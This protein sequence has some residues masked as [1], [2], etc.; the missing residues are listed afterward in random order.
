MGLFVTR[1]KL[2]IGAIITVLLALAVLWAER[3]RLGQRAG[4]AWLR[5]RG[6]PAAGEIEAI[7]PRGIVVRDLALGD[8][9]HPDLAAERAQIALAWEGTHPRLLAAT[10]VRPVLRLAVGRDGR[11]HLGALDRLRPP[12]D[13]TPSR[14]PDLALHLTDARLLASTPYGPLAATVHSDGNPARRFAGTLALAPARLTVAGCALPLT[15]GRLTIGARD[16]VGRLA[17]TLGLGALACRGVTAAVTSV[18]LDLT[19][20]DP[21]TRAHG[22]IVAD[23]RRAGGRGGTAERATI[24]FDGDLAPERVAGRLA[25]DASGGRYGQWHAARATYQGRLAFVPT[26]RALAL[27]GPL[28]IDHASLAP[29]AR[30]RLA[31]ASGGLA[32]TPLGP[33]EADIRATAARAAADFDAAGEVAYPAPPTRT[34]LANATLHARSGARLVLSGGDHLAIGGGGLPA[35]RVTLHGPADAT[36]SLAGYQAGTARLAATTLQVTGMPTGSRFRIDGPLL[37]DGPLGPG[38]VEGLALPAARFALNLAPLAITPLGC[39]PVRA[40]RVVEPRYTLADAAFTLCPARGPA[41]ALAPS[42]RLTGAF[43]AP[44]FATQAMLAGTPI[45]VRSGPVSVMLGGTGDAPVADIVTGPVRLVTPVG[46]TARTFDFGRLTAAAR[47][48]PAGW[49]FAGRIAGATSPGLP[50]TLASVAGPWSYSPAGRLAF[51]PTDTRVADLPGSRPRVQPLDLTGLA[52]TYADGVARVAAGVALA[53][54]RAPLARL[55][56]E[57]RAAT[58]TGTLDAAA[59]LAF[60][61]TLQPFQISERARG[62]IENVAGHVAARAHLRYTGGQISGT[63]AITLDKLS[64]ATASLGPVSAVSGTLTLPDLPNIASPPGQRFTIGGVNPGFAVA[65][66]VASLQLLSSTRVR[67]EE[68]GFPYVGGRLSLSPVTIDTAIPERRFTLTATGLDFA[69]FIERVQ[70]HNLDA[71]G[72]FDGTLPVILTNAG[73][74]I[75]HGLLT[76][77]AP[78]GRLRYVG[79]VGGNLPAAARLAF[80]ALRSMRYNSLRVGVD[81]DLGGDLVS[82]IAFTGAN[83]A[84]LTTGKRLPKLGPGVPFRFGVKIRA[85]F[86]ALLGTAASF[87]DATALIEA[88]RMA[89][90]R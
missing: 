82:D 26:T 88:G 55:T 43:G 23:V 80:E 5:A 59:E 49:A 47:S 13:G 81:G 34:P 76:A 42:G 52:L 85:P 38:R 37:L 15:G 87:E 24:A 90:P 60:T 27:T 66:G 86:R 12:P 18:R 44:A 9:A 89:P 56:G 69:R 40:A 54:T 79:P 29:A 2:A 22:R 72:I 21:L 75:D 51:G 84:P 45:G 30:A 71:T 14:L 17:G 28:R 63:A 20:P 25:I 10:L 68:L 74:R 41:L 61:P 53:A 1:R 65:G 50:F 67:I 64:F 48:T 78:G 62:V 19:L 3:A 6:V 35:M 8:P 70:I 73:G 46:G 39:M 16:R 58:A 77:R 7:G 32:A 83:E 36:I 11:V 57:Y 33:L 4:I 31:R